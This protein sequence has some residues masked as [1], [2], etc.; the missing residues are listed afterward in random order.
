MVT[1]DL[2][3]E[4][5]SRYCF[6]VAA[7]WKMWADRKFAR[8][9]PAMIDTSDDYWKAIGTKGRNMVRKS[10]RNDYDCQRFEFNDYLDD[11]YAINTSKVERQ[12]RPMTSSYTEHPKPVSFVESLCHRH[13][14][15]YV[16]VFKDERMWAYA[17]VAVSNDL[18]VLNRIIGHADALT[19]GVM[20][21]LVYGVEWRAAT[22]GVRF[23]NYLTMPS[24]TEGLEAFKRHVGFR[25]IE[26][27]FTL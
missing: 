25:A 14:T 22:A 1:C 13:R 12:G 6:D 5:S 24:A 27:E 23:I 4:C 9:P 8:V 15:V 7:A 3:G 18:A 17:Q 19:Y 10:A 11:V 26:T 20:N 16:G 2:I 21:A